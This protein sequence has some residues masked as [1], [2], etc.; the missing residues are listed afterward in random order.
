M[1]CVS[2]PF[3]NHDIFREKE[4]ELR[5]LRSANDSTDDT[6]VSHLSSKFT[7]QFQ[8]LC[9]LFRLYCTSMYAHEAVPYVC[10]SDSVSQRA[11]NFSERLLNTNAVDCRDSCGI[12][13]F[14]VIT[15]QSRCSLIIDDRII[16]IIPSYAVA[17]HLHNFSPQLH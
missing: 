15:I 11:H 5:S 13:T 8:A 2:S 14:I 3:F 6:T 4:E 17:T 10:F 16:P 12:Q 9:T 1:R 7:T